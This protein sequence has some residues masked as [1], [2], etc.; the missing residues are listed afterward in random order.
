MSSS[1]LAIE[2]SAVG[3]ITGIVGLIVLFISY[4]LVGETNLFGKDR[5]ELYVI[6]GSLIVTGML[7]HLMCE[8][9][10]INHWYCTNGNACI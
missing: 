9:S 5:K 1:R 7:I 6:I 4:K 10:G 2:A 3:V 8:Y